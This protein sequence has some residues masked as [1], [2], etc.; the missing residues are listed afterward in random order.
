VRDS[1]GNAITRRRVLITK[2]Q[3]NGKYC[4]SSPDLADPLEIEEGRNCNGR[5][6]LLQGACF[7]RS[8]LYYTV[9][10]PPPAFARRSDASSFV[11]APIPCPRGLSNLVVLCRALLSFAALYFKSIDTFMQY[12][13]SNVTRRHRLQIPRSFHFSRKT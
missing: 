10:Q 3:L 1:H 7:A 8:L 13:L 5:P 2:R 11:S 6:L 4:V 12:R 9:S